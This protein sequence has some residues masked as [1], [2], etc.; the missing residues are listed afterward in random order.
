ML[1]D[2]GVKARVMHAQSKEFQELPP[3]PEAKRKVW[4]RFTSANFR[5]SEALPITGFQTSNF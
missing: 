3:I 2:S 4:D 5:G 1:G